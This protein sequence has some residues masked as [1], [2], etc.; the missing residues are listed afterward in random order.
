LGNKP[1]MRRF[2]LG[3]ALFT[4]LAL[5]LPGFDFILF[6]VNMSSWLRAMTTIYLHMDPLSIIRHFRVR[7]QHLLNPSHTPRPLRFK[8]LGLERVGTKL[9]FPQ[10]D[11]LP[12]R[13][14]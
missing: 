10:G 14:G 2:W 1:L 12:A 4:G 8:Y 9:A 3:C 5:G 13:S 6:G 11:R 7:H